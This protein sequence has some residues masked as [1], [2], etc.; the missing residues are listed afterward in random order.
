[1][2]LF[3]EYLMESHKKYKFTIKLTFKPDAD[4]LDKIESALGR[5]DLDS[6]GKVQSLPIKKV[7][8]DFP[9]IQNPEIYQFPVVLNYPASMEFVRN[10]LSQVGIE[11]EQV[12]VV[13]T[14]HSAS[15]QTELDNTEANTS[16]TPLLMKDL[17]SNEKLTPQED[18]MGEKY[19]EKLIKNSGTS[20]F[21]PLKGWA[22]AAKTTNDSPMGDKSPVGSTTNKRPVPKSFFK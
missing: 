1:M 22:D 14:D 2:K 3:S 4:L 11:M 9:M 10:T 15:V 21:K 8:K 16:D 7:D 6:I 20:R 19:N 13:S 17:D 5:F 18:M 12:C